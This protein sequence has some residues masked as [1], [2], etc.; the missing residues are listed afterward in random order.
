MWSVI[1]ILFD[2]GLNF[3]VEDVFCKDINELFGYG[4]WVIW[5]WS[6]WG[7]FVFMGIY[8]VLGL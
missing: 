8:I 7:F 3:I 5:G 2:F 6:M 1:D 4:L